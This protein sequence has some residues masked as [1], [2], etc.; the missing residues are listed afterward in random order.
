VSW[1]ARQ[2]RRDEE[3]LLVEREGLERKVQSRTLDLQEANRL[4]TAEVAERTR[5]EKELTEEV[6]ERIRTEKELQRLNRAW[7]V[8][9]IFNRYVTRSG[10][11]ADLLRKVCG[12]MVEVG[13]YCITWAGYAHAGGVSPAAN[14]SE[15]DMGN[16]DTAWAPDSCGYR[17]AELAI[18]TTRPIPCNRQ[19]SSA[20]PGLIDDW[21]RAHGIKAALALPLVADGGVVGAL[22]TY[23]KEG[24]AFDDKE[25]ELFQQAANDLAQGITVLRTREA[26]AKT[27]A[28]LKKA[29]SDLAR[30]AR[31]TTM[32]ELTASI[33]HEVNQPL[34][35]L[36]TNANASLR[37]LA[38]EPPNYEQA[39]ITMQRIVRDGKRAAEVISRIRSM[40]SKGQDD[41]QRV[42]LN[43]LIQETIP[44]VQAELERRHAIL[45]TAFTDGLPEVEVDRVQIQQ[46]VMNLMVNALDA[47]KD[48]IDRPHVLKVR[49]ATNGNTEVVVAVQDCGIGID[50]EQAERLFT[51]FYST[52][53]EG[54]GMGLSISRSIM[55]A[56]GGR[57][58]AETNDGPGATFTLALPIGNAGQS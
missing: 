43:D 24:E 13:G 45:E 12:T 37:W 2:Q 39:R 44:M 33:A 18:R 7:R 32:G 8:R 57:L 17:L 56:H 49:T 5:A 51:A 36:V 19:N 41:R 53:A 29:E 11:E 9:T 21:A 47:M 16:I 27:E 6:S 25:T 48:V 42:S 50:E 28:A 31:V 52:K 10:N 30:V 22:I 38:A 26:R 3:A 54:M 1:L 4:L 35:S 23:S 34:A 15:T 20:T 46:V 40:L 58:W 14:A 55:E